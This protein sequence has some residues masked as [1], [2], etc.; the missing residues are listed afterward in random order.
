MNVDVAITIAES[1]LVSAV[2]AKISEVL[3]N[4]LSSQE[5]HPE[6]ILLGYLDSLK[7]QKMVGDYSVTAGEP[8]TIEGY[9]LTKSGQVIEHQL[10][11]TPKYRKQVLCDDW[12]TRK[13]CGPHR[14]RRL[15]HKY[16]KRFLRG[17]RTPVYLNIKPIDLCN[18]I[19]LDVQGQ[20]D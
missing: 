10:F 9:H 8:Y 7:E 15:L 11:A 5:E 17:E 12:F 6:K 18:L 2:Q 20:N 4:V 16:A 3:D 13:L 14:S 1:E 19:T